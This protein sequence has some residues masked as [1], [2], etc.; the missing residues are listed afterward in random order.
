MMSFPETAVSPFAIQLSSYE[1]RWMF[2]VTAVV[3]WRRIDCTDFRMMLIARAFSVGRGRIRGGYLQGH[4]QQRLM[5]LESADW[6]RR[7]A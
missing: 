5:L 2:S 6:R 7:L 3:H 4:R 1:F